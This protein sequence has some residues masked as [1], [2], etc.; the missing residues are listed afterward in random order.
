MI[1]IVLASLLVWWYNNRSFDH[2]VMAEVPRHDDLDE[3]SLLDG[4]NT[5]ALLEESYY[6][7]YYGFVHEGAEDVKDVHITIPSLNY[8]AISETGTTVEHN[9]DGQFGDV[10]ALRDE[11]SWVEYEV[12][13]PQ[14]GFYRIGMDYYALE[15]KRSGLVRSIQIN[16]EYPFYQA[17]QVEFQRM[18]QEYGEPWYDNQG[19]EYNPKRQEVFGWQ[20]RDFIDSEAKVAQGFRFY[21][22]KGTHT[23]RIDAIREPGAI[24]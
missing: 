23:I 8:S 10:I 24:G 2:N 1:L 13:I 21:F 4:E 20:Y 5:S 12:D 6:K 15:G 19:N 17:K 16:G 11:K 9:L 14:D 18:W 22:S 7:Y 3:S